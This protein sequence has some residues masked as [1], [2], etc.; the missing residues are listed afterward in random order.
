MVDYT[1][2]SK[3]YDSANVG[4][5]PSYILVDL[6]GSYVINKHLKIFGRIENMFNQYYEIAGGYGTPGASVFTGVKWSI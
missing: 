5:L 2:V 4:N 6:S 1:Y 3:V